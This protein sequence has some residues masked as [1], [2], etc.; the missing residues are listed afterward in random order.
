MKTALLIFLF[1]SF[2]L[3]AQA[4]DFSSFQKILDKNWI[5][6]KQDI[7]SYQTAFDYDK[8][9][10]DAT[11]PSLLKQQADLLEKFDIQQ[12]KNKNQATAFWINA[13]NFFMIKII[14][15]KGFEKDRR[16]IDSVKDFG[17]LFNPYKIFKKE[18]N[19]IGGK[20]YSLDDMEKGI[21]LGDDY[22]KKGWKDARIHFAVNC[23]SVGC[24]PLN[25]NT[26]SAK[27]LDKVLDD[28]ITKA[29]QTRRHFQWKG[30]S[31]VVT[32]LFKWYKNDFKE[33]SGS[34]KEFIKKYLSTEKF[35]KDMDHVEKIEYIE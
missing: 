10:K 18:L 4:Q 19:N 20:N 15:D 3:T 35:K 6:I 17:N 27:T 13:Y 32:H 29:L 26:Y 24:P 28:N 12:L 2:Y 23:A 25:K 34:V 16:E 1:S 9:K 8:A 21:L 14:L 5:E 33:H 7:N 11:T 30:P 31:I 22:K